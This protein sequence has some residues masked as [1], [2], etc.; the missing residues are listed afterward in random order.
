MRGNLFLDASRS[1]RLSANGSRRL[2]TK[3]ESETQ[4]EFVTKHRNGVPLVTVVG[5]VKVSH[6]VAGVWVRCPS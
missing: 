1:K 2:V 4:P 6:L 3:F 5:F